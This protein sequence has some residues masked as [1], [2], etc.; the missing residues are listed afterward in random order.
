MAPACRIKEKQREVYFDGLKLLAIFAVFSTHFIDRFHSEYFFLW[1]QPPT[2]WIL[3]GISGKLGVA[4]FS[5][6]LGFFAYRSSEASV[7]KYSLKRYLYFFVCGLFINIVYGILGWTGVFEEVW[8]VKQIIRTSVFLSDRIYATF[9][10]IKPFLIASILS[11]INGKAKP[12]VAGLLI[13]LAILLH[14][15]HIWTVICLMGNVA[16]EL[17]DNLYV[18]KI[19]SRRWVRV[20]IYITSINVIKGPES[21]ARYLIY[22]ITAAVIIITLKDS[23][24]VRKALEWKPVSDPGKNTM[25]IYLTHVVI[26]RIVGGIILS[27]A[28]GPVPYPFLFIAAFILSWAVIIAVSYPLTRLLNYAGDT[29]YRTCLTVYRKVS[30]IIIEGVW[31]KEEK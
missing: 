25:A 22:G 30:G 19:L 14:W 23:T 8:T 2:S 13:E 9:W 1:E 24:I 29:A 6:I 28:G 7:A 16:A 31:E 12:G 11:R 3:A 27:G 21:D 18:R 17:M 26:Y 15:G 20:L 5:V 10:C 4:F